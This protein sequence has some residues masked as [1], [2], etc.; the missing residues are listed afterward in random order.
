MMPSS[1]YQGSASNRG[2][3]RRQYFLGRLVKLLLARAAAAQPRQVLIYIQH[4]SVSLQ[5]K[6]YECPD[7]SV[8][9]GSRDPRQRHG[10][11]LSPYA[12]GVGAVIA[13]LH[14]LNQALEHGDTPEA[15]HR[16]GQ[17]RFFV[18]LTLAPG[19]IMVVPG[20]AGRHCP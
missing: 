2:G 11:R 18:G 4:I 19:L 16:V 10:L 13:P 8:C 14:Y 20:A 1:R 5:R 3:Q 15:Q 12:P 7:Y 6:G 9:T 17:I